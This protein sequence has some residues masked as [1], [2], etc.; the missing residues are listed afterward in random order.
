MRFTRSYFCVLLPALLM[1]LLFGC[2]SAEQRESELKKI[3]L[4]RV[5]TAGALDSLKG[6][7]RYAFLE[8]IGKPD[9]ENWYAQEFGTIIY[10]SLQT[11]LDPNAGI[12]MQSIMITIRNNRVIEVD[13]L[14]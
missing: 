13:T 10:D 7:H 5:W 1:V 8:T 2:T 6:M 11:R 4:G 14:Y 12:R 9:R 3:R